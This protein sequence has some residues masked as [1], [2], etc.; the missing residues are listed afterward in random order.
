MFRTSNDLILLVKNLFFKG[1]RNKQYSVFIGVKKL[2][3]SKLLLA[4]F[5]MG[6]LEGQQGNAMSN[7]DFEKLMQIIR[8]TRSSEE[9]FYTQISDYFGG[10]LSILNSQAD[11]FMNNDRVQSFVNEFGYSPYINMDNPVQYVEEY[12]ANPNNKGANKD[13]VGGYNFIMQRKDLGPQIIQ[14]QN[15]LQEVS[16]QE[17][18][19]ALEPGETYIEVFPDGRKV[20]MVK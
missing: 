9:V 19:D 20:K 10:R 5:R 6:R 12:L 7:R 1:G 8:P 17:Q 15:Q 11:Q 14:G 2:F 13:M 3:E 16:T 4:A 18:F